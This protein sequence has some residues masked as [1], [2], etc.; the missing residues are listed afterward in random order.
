MVYRRKL[1][2][3]RMKAVIEATRQ[4]EMGSYKALGSFNIQ[5]TTL[6]CYVKDRQIPLSEGIEAALG[7]NESVRS[8]R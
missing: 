4:I 1:D 2:P 3:K 7:M 8:R 6:Y 5:Q